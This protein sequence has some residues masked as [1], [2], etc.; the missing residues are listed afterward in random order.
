MGAPPW[1]GDAR[2]LNT[3]SHGSWPGCGPVLFFGSI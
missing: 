1:D 3:G 2:H